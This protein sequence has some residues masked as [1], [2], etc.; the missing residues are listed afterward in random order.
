MS[1]LPQVVTRNW[2]LKLA[3]FG[4]AVFL[5]AV[6]TVQPRNRQTLTSV[7]VQ[8]VVNDPSWTLAEPPVPSSVDVRLGGPTRELL[9]LARGVEA[10]VVRI[11]IEAVTDRDTVVRLRNDWVRLNDGSGLVVEAILPATVQLRFEPTDSTALPLS[12]RVRNELPEGLSLA[13]PLGLTPPVVR[14]RGP[15]RMVEDLDSIPLEPLDLSAVDRSGQYTV[16]VDTA[17]LGGLVVEPTGATL[18]VFLEPT[19]ER[20][21]G[22]VPVVLEAAEGVDTTSLVF[23][24]SSIQVTL[25]GART[26]VNQANVEGLRAVVAAADVQGLVPAEEREVTIRVSGVP[27]LVRAFSPTTTVRVRRESGA[28]ADTVPDTVR[29]DTVPRDTVGVPAVAATGG[30]SDHSRGTGG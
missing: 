20:V 9:Q 28:D 19:V 26:L 6:V 2:R 15:S 16:A 3:A 14:V 27:N 8:V 10:G 5:W 22:G 13:Q 30:P 1:V 17:G 12:V 11:P 4:L 25:M 18:S 7:P 29:P 23:S 24:P 21:I